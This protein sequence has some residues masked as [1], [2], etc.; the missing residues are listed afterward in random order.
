MHSII[1]LAV[2]LNFFP[3]LEVFVYNLA[4]LPLAM[5]KRKGQKT[6]IYSCQNS[7]NNNSLEKIE[8]C[9]SKP[10]R[11]RKIAFWN[12]AEVEA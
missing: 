1:T 5:A 8:P 9:Y 12:R 6:K 3:V 10:T 2:Y 4:L 11:D 7:Q